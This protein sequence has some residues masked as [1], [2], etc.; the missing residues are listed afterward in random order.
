MSIATRNVSTF[1]RAVIRISGAAP[2]PH[3]AP[4][5][6]PG[7]FEGLCNDRVDPCGPPGFLYKNRRQ[8]P[9]VKTSTAGAEAFQA[10]DGGQAGFGIVEYE[11]FTVHDAPAA[12]RGTGWAFGQSQRFDGTGKAFLCGRVGYGVRGSFRKDILF[13]YLEKRDAIGPDVEVTADQQPFQSPARRDSNRR[14]S[15]TRV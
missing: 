9:P 10:V 4:G 13:R 8:Y 6:Q 1:D 5:V 14:D 11:Q 12:G 7:P 3:P 2:S 15:S